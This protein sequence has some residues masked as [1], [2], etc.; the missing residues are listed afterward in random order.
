MKIT[1]EEI[2]AAAR[3]DAEFDKRGWLAMPGSERARYLMR[4]AKSLEAA[5]EARAARQA[6][7]RREAMERRAAGR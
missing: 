7:D 3:S 6:A 5:A 4:A 2:A 1:D